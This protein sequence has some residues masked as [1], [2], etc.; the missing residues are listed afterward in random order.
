[1]HRPAK[2]IIGTS[3]ALAAAMLAPAADATFPGPNGKIA[4][5]RG[6]NVW[7]MNP[8]GTGQV[9]LTSSGT[10]R[11]PQ[12][13]P[14]GRRSAYDQASATTAR[15]IWVMDPNGSARFRVTTHVKNEYDPAWSPDG[16]WL[17]FVS[18]RRGRGEIFKLPST[19]PFGT[20]IRL[21]TTAGTG[22][23]YPTYENP[24]LSDSAPNWSPRGD[25]IAFI[26]HMREDDSSYLGFILLMMTMNTDGTDIREPV[27]QGGYGATCPSW[28]PGGARIAWVDD[29]FELD[30]GAT[31][32][33]W[34]SNP[35]G[36][37]LVAVT[38]FE[39]DVGWTWDLGCVSWSPNRGSRIVFDGYRDDG[40]GIP[41]IYSVP[42]GGTSD[43][44][45]LARNAANPDWGR[46]PA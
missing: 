2:L 1:M 22:E 13:S 14:D 43:P 33:V 5:E 12:W 29:E 16:R 46:I 20:A 45:R 38:H 39:D 11:N 40:N 34:Q 17:A 37:G 23:P 18:D 26:R 30:V 27:T 24:R 41:A 32:N 7:V 8:N 21:T 35:D 25:R 44:V 19:V 36:S 4:F 15:D 6:G 42:S 28:G 9:R 3:V 31:N 10:A